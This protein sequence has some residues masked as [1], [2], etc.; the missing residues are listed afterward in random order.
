MRQSSEI[1]ASLMPDA[2]SEADIPIF[3]EFEQLF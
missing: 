3:M 2:G 1:H